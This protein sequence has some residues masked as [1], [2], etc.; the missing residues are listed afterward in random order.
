M[1]SKPN[2]RRI[3]AKLARNNLKIDFFG[4]ST[5]PSG[6]DTTLDV[7]PVR[8]KSNSGKQ[9]INLK[10]LLKNK[11]EYDRIKKESEKFYSTLENYQGSPDFSEV[12]VMDGE[13]LFNSS[14]LGSGHLDTLVPIATRKGVSSYGLIL[15]KPNSL[16]G[17]LINTRGTMVIVFIEIENGMVFF[18]SLNSI[19]TKRTRC[20]RRIQVLVIPDEAF[21]IHNESSDVTARLLAISCSKKC[22][23]FDNLRFK[24][25]VALE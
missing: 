20:K 23:D 5:E 7:D 10:K 14:R 6:E 15:I 12:V 16:Y 1:N 18:E 8:Q 17:P 3:T 4:N 25:V 13:A 19:K 2:R 21:V 24:E 11:E 9:S 22:K